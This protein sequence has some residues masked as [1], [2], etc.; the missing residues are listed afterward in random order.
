[1]SFAA[2]PKHPEFLYRH[3]GVLVL[4]VLLSVVF[5]PVH[6]YAQAKKVRVAL[7]AIPSLRCHFL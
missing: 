1:M 6:S 2:N 4:S 5:A 3:L 7:P